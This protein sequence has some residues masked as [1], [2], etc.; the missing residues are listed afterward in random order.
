METKHTP[1]REALMRAWVAGW[2]AGIQGAQND[3]GKRDTA[4]EIAQYFPA[5][6]AAPDLLT[7]CNRVVDRRP[8][9]GLAEDV[10]LEPSDLDMLN[11][12]T[13]KA[14]RIEPI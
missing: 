10:L 5:E 7:A 9:G 6:E 2:D 8:I 11:A 14:T 4:Q 12:A 3:D 1:F 13:A